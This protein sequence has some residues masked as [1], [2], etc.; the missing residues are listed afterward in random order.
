MNAPND[1]EALAEAAWMD[2]SYTNWSRGHRMGPS[3]YR[4]PETVRRENVEL[5]KKV[6]ALHE[7]GIKGLAVRDASSEIRWLFVEKLIELVRGSDLAKSAENARKVW[8]PEVVDLRQLRVAHNVLRAYVDTT[9]LGD[10]DDETIFEQLIARLPSFFRDTPGSVGFAR[11][12]TLNDLRAPFGWIVD[13][14]LKGRPFDYESIVKAKTSVR[15]GQAVG[16][17][18]S[19][20]GEVQREPLTF[21]RPQLDALA[22]YYDTV[23]GPL[24]AVLDVLR[25]EDPWWRPQ[26][27]SVEVILALVSLVISVQRNR[28][29]KIGCDVLRADRFINAAVVEIHGDA[30]ENLARLAYGQVVARTSG[31]WGRLDTKA[32]GEW[33]VLAAQVLFAPVLPARR[34]SREEETPFKEAVLRFANVFFSP[35]ITHEAHAWHNSPSTRRAVSI[36]VSEEDEQALRQVQDSIT[37]RAKPGVNDEILRRVD[38]AERVEKVADTQV[39]TGRSAPITSVGVLR[40]AADRLSAIGKVLEDDL[41]AVREHTAGGV[42]DVGGETTPIQRISADPAA[43]YD[44]QHP[45]DVHYF[46]GAPDDIRNVTPAMLG[47]FVINNGKFQVDSVMIEGSPL[48]LRLFPNEAHDIGAA[49]NTRSDL[50]VI[51]RSHRPGSAATCFKLTGLFAIPDTYTCQ[52]DGATIRET[53]LCQFDKIES[54]NPKQ[55]DAK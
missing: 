40:E 39:F 10:I 28:L 37:M 7:M 29:S 34:V 23:K 13:N 42:Q 38:K 21:T 44:A 12:K 36:K 41:K 32:R 48:L 53:I 55:R 22:R 15:V 1:V 17:S 20:A 30:I 19:G 25:T 24:A 50:G 6:F 35:E 45:D 51:F 49:F 16:K 46:P 18:T 14:M 52:P 5:S 31:E 9:A 3:W 26:Y 54:W 2:A 11:P 4:L 33:C 27:H 8:N 43:V 47:Y